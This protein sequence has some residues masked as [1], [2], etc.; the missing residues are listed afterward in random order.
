MFLLYLTRH[1]LYLSVPLSL[2]LTT[3]LYLYPAFH[4]CAFPAPEL[5]A[6]SAYTNTL[7]Q[8]AI[9]PI[10]N[11]SKL[12]PFRLLALGDPQLE[13]DSSIRDVEA[14]GLPH[15]WRFFENVFRKKQGPLQRLRTGL[16]D[17]IDF[18]LDD[19]PKALNVWRKRFDHVG[20][21]YYLGHIYR[22]MHWW[23]DPT[24][25]TALGDLVGSQWIDDKEFE[26]RGRRFWDR[27][28]RGGERV[29]DEVAAGADIGITI[30]LG[31]DPADWK[32]RII[33]V[34]GNHD[35]GYAGDL[36]KE[37]LERFDRVFGKPNYELRFQLP[38]THVNATMEEEQRPTPQ[39]RIVVFNDMNLDTPV[40]D[41][42]LQTE[43]YQFLN[44]M[45]TTSQ[46]VT[47]PAIFTIVLTH[48]PLFKNAG[49]C[50]DPP[51]FDF[52]END[53]FNG[54]V[55]EQNHL[56]R[57]ASNG[58]L[59]GI[60]GM[61]GDDTVAGQGK[62]RPGTILTGHDHEG[63]DI[64][65]YINQTTEI[66]R[67][68]EAKRWA[69]V[70]STE[71]LKA[72]GIPGMREITVRS[73]M[74]D[75]AGNAGLMSLWFDKDIWDWK[76]EF[77][78]CGLGTQHIWWTVHVWLFI[79]LILIVICGFL[80]VVNNAQFRQ[81]IKNLKTPRAPHMKV[82]PSKP[83]PRIE[84]NGSLITTTDLPVRDDI[85]AGVALNVPGTGKKG[86][87][88]KKSKRALNGSANSSSVSVI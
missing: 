57:A 48:I 56:S 29:P 77:V 15:F 40:S 35:V 87:R 28:F 74:G 44:K 2:I 52:F 10:H 20:N 66:D 39:L 73:M 8:H 75:F 7:W 82:P 13:G 17:V 67:Q 54:G 37:R 25:V 22:T 68:W 61:S 86:P 45:I 72:E 23:T 41:Q 84:E 4:L 36:S 80:A 63:C 47:R 30:V 16:H 62:G 38:E 70:Q 53:A 60:F 79:N 58:L 11:G 59:E 14:A 69:D 83:V 6:R 21:D 71:L 34:A 78:N 46:E 81:V 64:Y 50:V 26:S 55:K 51:F 65:H 76:Y 42:E 85:I 43:T 3:Y 5:D 18:Y 12:A 31:D 1:A 32:R 24:H 19:I 27:V 33:N 49:M 88:K 9:P